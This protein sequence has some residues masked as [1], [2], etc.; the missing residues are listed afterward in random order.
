LRHNGRT[1]LFM[2][3]F[4]FDTMRGRIAVAEIEDGGGVTPA[5]PALEESYH[6]SYPNVFEHDGDIWMVPESGANASIDL[7]RGVEFPDRWVHE[8]RLLEG[9]EA[10]DATFM[11]NDM[12]WWMFAA[13]RLRRA[14]GWDSLSIFSAP[15]LRGPWRSC[16]RNPVVIDAH[17][18]RPAGAVIAGM[19]AHLRP[20][21]DCAAY[22]G[23]AIGLWRIDR[24]DREA[25]SQRQVAT[26]GSEQFGVHTYNS[27]QAIEVV[28]AFGK[29]RGH[30]T[31]IL[32]CVDDRPFNDVSPANPDVALWS[33]TETRVPATPAK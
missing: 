10:Y 13:T 26:I 16:E 30:S 5:R 3:E 6:L 21:Q 18:A 15:D 4:P 31:V 32:T 9:L 14:T 33:E 23:A 19:G 7:Y 2:E 28:D 24:I 12:G 29:T 25:F 11:H 17:A 20:V 27:A 8:A 1:A 22:Y